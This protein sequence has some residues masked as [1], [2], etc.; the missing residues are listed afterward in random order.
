MLV[1]V[2]FAVLC[3]AAVL[4]MRF[5]AQVE[6]D[7]LL[8]KYGPPHYSFGVEELAIRDF[9]QDRT[10]GFFVD[11]GAN[12]YKKDSNTFYLEERLGWSGIAVDAVREYE[13]DYQRYRPHTRFFARFVSD[14]SG[15]ES[16]LFVPADKRQSS[17]W[18]RPEYGPAEER[19]VPTITLNDLLAQQHVK[20]MDLL[21]LDIEMS[22]PKA[23]AGFDV[24]R[25]RPALVCVE[26]HLPVR[27]QILDYFARH[28]YTVVGRY[29][30]ADPRN[31]YFAPLP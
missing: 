14:V 4:S 9:F 21:S 20:G 18:R 7:L 29:L 19:R 16:A 31:L 24:E 2:M 6:R 22:E 10:G 13:A 12:H 17:D 15:K 11:I 25:F 30:R 1:I 3:S 5:Q 28:G 8:K 23:L 27:Q 26:A